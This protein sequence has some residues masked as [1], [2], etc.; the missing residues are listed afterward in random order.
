MA[1]RHR[2]S[3]AAGGRR[4]APRPPLV[5]C[6]LAPRD[7]RERR[8]DWAAVARD[9]LIGRSV[10]PRGLRLRFRRDAAVGAALRRLVAQEAACCSAAVF[11][12]VTAPDH[13]AVEIE[14]T[15]AA[16]SALRRAF[17]VR[18]AGQGWRGGASRASAGGATA[19]AR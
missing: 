12:L 13:L 19:A 8:A 7:L 1:G 2:P 4:S 6:S 3:R 17:G 18:G 10:R 11:R 5:G 16:R 15:P 14:A 9:A